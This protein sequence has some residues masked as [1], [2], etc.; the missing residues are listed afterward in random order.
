[1]GMFSQNRTMLSEDFEVQANESYVGAAGAYRAMTEGYQN[2]YA[3]FESCIGLDFMEAAVVNEAGDIS[4]F[5]VVQEG[6]AGDFFNKIKEFLTKLIEKIKGIVKSFIAKVTGTFCRD[7]KKLVDKYK[8]DVLKKDLSKMKY[9]WQKVNNDVPDIKT[10]ELSKIY[11]DV[12]GNIST[13]DV[14]GYLDKIEKTRAMN[15]DK[16]TA[17][18]EKLNDNSAMEKD[19]GSMCTSGGSGSCELSEFSK[20]FHDY[21]YQD[22]EECE[23]FGSDGANLSEIMLDLS[24]GKK[25]ISDIE[26]SQKTHE[27]DV[28]EL[29]KKVDTAQKQ[30]L[31]LVPDKNASDKRKTN[32]AAVN[33]GLNI[34]MTAANQIS[35]VTTKYFACLLD[36]KKKYLA[37]CKKVFVQAASYRPKKT[38]ESVL[39]AEA[40]GEVAEYETLELFDNVVGI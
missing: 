7:G 12:L 30:L 6:F 16:F 15:P 37:R 31:K 26:K 23:G 5:E 35:T 29:I 40:A 19:L 39:F 36:E 38:N 33:N 22:E 27:K 17:E 10:T 2:S 1:M 20:E 32:V 8:A 4:E 9:K 3:V 11:K 25:A 28:K 34:A 13:E 24:T 18:E 21:L 14:S